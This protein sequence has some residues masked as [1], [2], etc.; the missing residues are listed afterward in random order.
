M[1]EKPKDVGQSK[2]QNSKF[3]QNIKSQNFDFC[4]CPN[5][6]VVKCDGSEKEYMSSA[7]LAHIQPEK[8]QNVQQV[9]FWQKALGVNGFKMCLLFLVV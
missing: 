1:I 5:K 6:N 4:P 9:Y 3:S 7:N 2:I 8:L